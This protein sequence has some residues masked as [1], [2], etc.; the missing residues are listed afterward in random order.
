MTLAALM[1]V[2]YASPPVLAWQV[3]RFWAYARVVS[4]QREQADALLR[5]YHGR[6]A[7][8]GVTATCHVRLDDPA[9]A[10]PRLAAEIGAECVV[11]PTPPATDLAPFGYWWNLHR[12]IRQSGIPV[13]LG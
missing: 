2:V 9:K 5:A 13:V 4:W 12:L 8:Q 10:I 7:R 1:L 11:F 6:L 3:L